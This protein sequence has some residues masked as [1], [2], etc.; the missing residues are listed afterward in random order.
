MPLG[1][2]RRDGGVLWSLIL[3][4]FIAVIMLVLTLPAGPALGAHAALPPDSRGVTTD[5]RAASSSGA[6]PQTPY[7]VY[8]LD[9]CTNYLYSGNVLPTGCSGIRPSA[10]AYDS[11]KGEVFVANPNQQSSNVSVISDVTN[12]V[13]ATIPVGNYPQGVA[14]DSGKGEIFVANEISDNVSVIS[15]VSNSVVATIPVGSGPSAVA[16]DSG[17]GEVFVTSR[18]GV[19]VISDTG[20][21]VTSTVT[22]GYGL[23]SVAYDPAN[24]FAY[25]SNAGIGAISIIG[26]HS[27]YSVNFSQSGLPT[28]TNW[29]L[30]LDNQTLFS[31]TSTITFNEPNG[32][33]SFTVISAGNYLGPAPT[34]ASGNVTVAGSNVRVVITFPWSYHSVFYERGLPIG[35]Q[36]SFWL[37][38][39]NGVQ[40]KFSS[41]QS[42]ISLQLANGTWPF[43]VNP[44]TGY[45][46]NPA[47]GAM[48]VNGSAGNQTI[49]FTPSAGRYSVSFVEIG[50][51]TGASWSISLNGTVGHA[52]APASLVFSE[53]NGT[54][55]F[56]VGTV[57]G[58]TANVSSGNLTVKGAA[59]SQPISFTPQTTLTSVTVSPSSDTLKVGTFANFTATPSC[60]SG[61]CSGVTYSWALNNSLGILNTTSGT[62]VKFTAI[63]SGTEN[64]SVTAMLSGQL[65]KNSSIV[66]ITTTPV[67]TL[68]YVSLTPVATTVNVSGTQTFTAAV[69]CSGGTCPSGSTYVWSLN[70]SLGKLNV[71]SG[72]QVLFTANSTAGLVTLTV[73]AHLNGK[74]ATN[75]STITIKK[76]SPPPSTYAV[77]FSESGLPSGTSWSVT[78]NAVTKSGTGS[79]IFTEL[80]GTY[81]FFLGAVSGYTASPSSGTITV[82][83]VAVNRAITFTALPPGQY[84]LV[85][86][87]TSLPAGVNWSV[88]VGTTTH[89]STGSTISFAEVNGTYSYTV[90]A[91]KGYAAAPSSGNVTINGAPKTVSITF[92]RPSTIANYAVTFTETGLPAGTSWSATLNG[93]TKSSTTATITFQEP[94]GSYTFSV[95]SV[96]GYTVGPSP[97]TIKVNGAAVSQPITFTSSSSQGKGNQTTGFLGLPGYDGYL[98]VGIIVAAVAAGSLIL[99]LRKRSPPRGSDSVED[100]KNI[101]DGAA[102]QVAVE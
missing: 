45:S 22:V 89:T 81:P 80:N 34:P 30:A 71:S 86:S 18:S 50:L 31:T 55:P 61:P 63:A 65:A 10:V 25:A 92:L 47:S 102:S 64:L 33:Y 98:V 8:T 48:V 69:V 59:V 74:T 40:Y 84:S 19:S 78:L 16:Y 97:G 88:T 38:L 32:T 95:G 96:S 28:G 24:G 77:T 6:P 100:S 43:S 54:Y 1:S 53:S 29:S 67:P 68:A 99:L 83:G 85:F 94:N 101:A 56:T 23:S 36:W 52:V 93:S 60:T 41:Y 82:S 66:T 75:S 58:Y 11:G 3:P 13:V 39:P 44:V 46:A 37:T 72:P 76:S 17:K 35:T 15:D 20:D 87:T 7:V 27:T 90:G 5:V 91:V 79:I 49:V 42:S 21:N 12:K 26:A 73:T 9:L 62:T 57:T 4:I 70:N 2:G 14:Y 51:S